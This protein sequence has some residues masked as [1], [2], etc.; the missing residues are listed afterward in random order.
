V[1]ITNPATYTRLYPT[2]SPRRPKVSK[3]A[4]VA[5]RKAT[6]THSISG[7]LTSKSFARVG[8]EML[9]MLA[10]RVDMKVP[11][12]TADRTIHLPAPCL[13][14]RPEDRLPVVAPGGCLLISESNLIAYL[15]ILSAS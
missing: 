5:R 13:V 11:K 4:P 8:S 15:V 7:M 9:T 12:E 3:S 14:P 2:I 1:K 10:L 6:T